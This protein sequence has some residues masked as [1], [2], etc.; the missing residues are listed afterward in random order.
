[1][2]YVH[3][4]I[5]IHIAKLFFYQ[6]HVKVLGLHILTITDCKKNQRF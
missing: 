1:M 2:E 4:L 3:Y 5:L 6:H